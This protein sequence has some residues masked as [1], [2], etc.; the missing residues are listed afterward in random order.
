MSGRYMSKST[1]FGV[2]AARRSSIPD[3]DPNLVEPY[4]H[5]CVI[6]A[7]HNTD[8]DLGNA[9]NRVRDSFE[10]VV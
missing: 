6:A 10:S 7:S 3:S 2:S 4:R 8:V 1:R 5:Q 9:S